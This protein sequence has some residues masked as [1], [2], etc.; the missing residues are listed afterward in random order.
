MRVCVC[1]Y[2]YIYRIKLTQLRV[3]VTEDQQCENQSWEFLLLYYFI[4][5]NIVI[6]L[7]IFVHRELKR[8]YWLKILLAL[9]INHNCVCVYIYIYIYI[10]YITF[11]R[12]HYYEH[13]RIKKMP[14]F[15]LVYFLQS[16]FTY[17]YLFL[18]SIYSY[19]WL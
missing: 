12:G 9:N 15:F 16:I 8:F 4:L 6:L 18:M 7:H 3:W 17:F 14:F 11:V 10:L 1:I 2:I 19:K 5:E 13:N